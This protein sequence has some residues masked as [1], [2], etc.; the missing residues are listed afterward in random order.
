MTTR[1]QPVREFGA[2]LPEMIAGAGGTIDNR[3]WISHYPMGPEAERLVYTIDGTSKTAVIEWLTA[4]PNGVGAHWIVTDEEISDQDAIRLLA[5]HR[6]GAAPGQHYTISYD[7]EYGHHVVDTQWPR[8]LAADMA[9]T[10]LREPSWGK[11]TRITIEAV[12]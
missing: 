10:L 7:N 6:A 4:A 12:S 2:M 5:D 3:R 9:G 1:Y 8:E 11:I